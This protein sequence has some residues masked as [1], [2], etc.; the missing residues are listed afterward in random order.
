MPAVGVAW[1][2]P[3]ACGARL[4]GGAGYQFGVGHGNG[5]DHRLVR[6]RLMHSEPGK[7]SGKAAGQIA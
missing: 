2:L 7:V 4:G 5:G 3:Q 6:S 1:G